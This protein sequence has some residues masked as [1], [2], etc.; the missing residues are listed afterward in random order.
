MAGAGSVEL[1]DDRR[2][3]R[4][5]DRRTSR[6]RLRRSGSGAGSRSA[7]RPRSR[8]SA[9]ATVAVLAQPEQRDVLRRRE[10]DLARVARRERVVGAEPVQLVGLGAV[11]DLVAARDRRRRRT[12]SRTASARSRASSSSRGGRACRRRRR[13]P[14]PPSLRA[15]RP[16]RGRGDEV[17]G[18][19]GV[20]VGIDATAGEH[21]RAAVERELRR[22]PG[23]QHL[24]PVVAVAQQ[25]DRRG[26]APRST[27]WRGLGELAASR[28]SLNPVVQ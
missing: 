1:R 8:R 4:L 7:S 12:R 3:R 18:R 26:R 9:S 28:R 16:A 23:E 11:G 21:P 22:P 5:R 25:H 6:R 14:P 2:T 24:E 17:V 19:V 15:P 27:P 20:V 13:R 10:L